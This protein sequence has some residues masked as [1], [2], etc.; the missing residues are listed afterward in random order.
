MPD[1]LQSRA[2]SVEPTAATS[3]FLCFPRED[4]ERSVPERFERQVEL[5]PDKIAVVDAESTVTYRELNRLANRIAH[6]V[7]AARGTQ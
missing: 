5:Y 7:L 2:I 3:G 6:E 4:V 1:T